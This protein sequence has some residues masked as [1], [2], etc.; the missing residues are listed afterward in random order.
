MEK[1]QQARYF[2]KKR[3]SHR[4]GSINS[5]LSL[6]ELQFYVSSILWKNALPET[7]SPRRLLF[8]LQVAR[9]LADFDASEEIQAIHLN[10]AISHSLLPCQKMGMY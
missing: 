5:Q 4:K 6:K 10:Q 2:I 3:Q 1:I 7:P 8:V 9:S